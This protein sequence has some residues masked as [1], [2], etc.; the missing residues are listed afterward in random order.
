VDWATQ[1]LGTTLFP[2]LTYP[3]ILGRKYSLFL[4]LLVPISLTS[5]PYILEQ[6]VK[7]LLSSII[8]QE[9]KITNSPISVDL[10][11]TVTSIGTSITR[12]QPGDRVLAFSTS[13]NPTAGTF[14]HF[15]P[16]QENTTSPIPPSLNFSDACVLPACLSVAAVGLFDKSYLGLQL[17]ER[18]PKAAG[19][20]VLVWGAS[21]SVG[22]NAVQLAIAAGYEV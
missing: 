12:F 16:A 15:V 3:R 5:S 9:N 20:T 13:S 2:F 6:I 22:C 4:K 10:A 17:P 7:D 1:A 19:K 11:G 21:T 14:Q 18:E 8:N